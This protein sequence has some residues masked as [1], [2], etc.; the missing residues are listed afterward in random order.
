MT[1]ATN[2]LKFQPDFQIGQQVWHRANR[3][4]SG[5]IDAI[6]LYGR[7]EFRYRVSWGTA[8]CTEERETTL[9]DEQ[10]TFDGAQQGDN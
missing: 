4:M 8:E 9:T 1:P 7:E 10:P 5:M 2:T 3:E 6:V